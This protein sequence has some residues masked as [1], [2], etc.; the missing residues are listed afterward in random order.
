[1][2]LPYVEKNILEH[3]RKKRFPFDNNI[4]PYPNAA[5]CILWC[6]ENLELPFRSQ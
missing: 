5:C 6:I 4:K 1:M 3:V 2:K